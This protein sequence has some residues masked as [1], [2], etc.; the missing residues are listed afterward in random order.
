MKKFLT[1]WIG[2]FI[3]SVG[4]G[5]SAF[6]LGVYVYQ[7]TKS[8]VAFSIVT[9][10]AY[11]PNIILNPFVGVLADRF[12]RKLLMIIGDSFSAV[13]LMFILICSMIGN[14]QF[15]QIC[16]GVA[17]GSIFIS[18]L[19]PAYKATITDLLPKEQYAKASGLV[20]LAASAKYLISPALAGFFLAFTDIKVILFID[21]LTFLVSI[22]A[23]SFVR[24]SLDTNISNEEKSSFFQ[25]FKEGWATVISNK[26][27]MILVILMALICMYVGFLQ[28]L[29]SPM[30]LSFTDSKTL[31]IIESV[32]AFGMLIG[33]LIVGVSE[34]KRN[35]SRILSWALFVSGIAMMGIGFTTNTWIIIGSGIIF[36][37]AIPFANTSA[38]TLV[39]LNIPNEIQGRAW[40]V[41]AVLSQ[42]G[43]VVA[44][45]LSGVLADYVLNPLLEKDGPLAGSIGRVI[46]VGEGRGIAL[47]MIAAGFSIIIVAFIMSRVKL[48]RKMENVQDVNS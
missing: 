7:T 17:A 10:L 19:D 3:S 42:V 28:T 30:I 48:L 15:W 4:S 11:L 21:I 13:S 26:G 38:D 16:I 1:I 45:V 31:G 40:G 5:M 2:E 12:D 36:F 39:R 44:Y 14:L 41:I 27:I 23:I 29:M 32:S 18:L 47:L 35:Y 24:K 6:A 25:D 20:Q 34:I 22:I 37:M 33:S 9:L 8:A 46:G 43:Y